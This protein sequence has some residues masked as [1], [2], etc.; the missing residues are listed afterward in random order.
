MG[1]N[2]P[3]TKM[4][5]P[6]GPFPLQKPITKMPKPKST[7]TVWKTDTGG[8]GSLFSNRV[9]SSTGAASLGYLYEC[10]ARLREREDGR[11]K[12]EGWFCFGRPQ[13]L[14]RFE[15]PEKIVL[16]DVCNRGTCFLDT[17]EKWLLDTAYAIV[18]KPNV[19]FDLRY[20]I[21]ILNSPLITSFLKET[22]TALRVG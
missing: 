17:E 1:A 22:G 6:A 14:D 10:Q 11:F 9:C 16:P 18:K 7:N 21:A 20:L 8:G 4:E 12:G 2:T 3:L 19:K 5:P 15:V 13:N